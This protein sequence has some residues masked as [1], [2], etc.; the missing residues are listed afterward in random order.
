MSKQYLTERQWEVVSN[1]KAQGARFGFKDMENG[2][3][4]LFA[5]LRNG[6]LRQL[7]AVDSSKLYAF[8]GDLAAS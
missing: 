2:K 8:K 1:L 4:M 5:Y 3:H 7:I 6:E